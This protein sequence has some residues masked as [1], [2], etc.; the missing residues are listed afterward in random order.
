V[1]SLRYPGLIGWKAAAGGGTTDYAVEIYGEALKYG[2][3]TCFLKEDMA[4]PMMY[5]PDAI[6]ATL[7]LMEAPKENI[8]IRTSYNLAGMSFTPQ[9]IYTEIKKYKSDFQI[10]Y[11]PD[12][13]QSIAATWVDSIDDSRA[14]EDW[15]WKQKYHLPTM[16]E[17]M[18]LNLKKGL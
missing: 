6:R 16:V 11:E 1:R 8:K 12:F 2:N 18:F 3:F 5:M 15:G 14:A 9:E 7:E 4:L 17:D 13:R 10:K